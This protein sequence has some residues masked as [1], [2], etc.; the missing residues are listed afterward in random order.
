MRRTLAALEVSLWM[1][2]QADL[3][4]RAHVRAAAELARVLAVADLDHAHDVAV[5]LAEQRHRAEPLGLLER[6]RD[7]AHRVVGEDPGVD[8]V[9]DVAQLLARS[10][11]AEWLKSKRSLSGP[12]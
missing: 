10:A 1:W 5:L 6:R 11:R 12:T 7:R 2:Q 3:G 9:L 8:L 4:G